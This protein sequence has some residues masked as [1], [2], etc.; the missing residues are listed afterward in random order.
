MREQSSKHRNEEQK[1]TVKIVEIME[2][3][4]KTKW[5]WTKQS[6]LKHTHTRMHKCKKKL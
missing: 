3:N 5:K 6:K 2:K 4:K 1:K